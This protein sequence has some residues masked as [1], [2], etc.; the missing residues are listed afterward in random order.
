MFLDRERNGETKIRRMINLLYI[1]SRSTDFMFPR[2]HAAAASLIRAT[3]VCA[4]SLFFASYSR[5]IIRARL[6]G[7]FRRR[8][9]TSD[10]PVRGNRWAE[11]VSETL[12]TVS[13]V[14]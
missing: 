2:F 9:R 10:R 1:S 5:K 12:L 13:N 7:G 6:A 3:C 11:K 4:D 14:N 8:T